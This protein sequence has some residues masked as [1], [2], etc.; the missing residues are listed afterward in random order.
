LDGRAGR[1]LAFE[2]EEEGLEVFLSSLHL[3]G[4]ALRGVGDPPGQ[5]KVGCQAIDVGAEADAL[6]GAPDEDAKPL[7]S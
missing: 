1:P 7:R 3:D 4:D 6:H 5:A 2:A